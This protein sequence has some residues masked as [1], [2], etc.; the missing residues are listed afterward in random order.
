MAITFIAWATSD[1]APATTAGVDTTGANLLIAWV[2]TYGAVTPTLT[3]SKSNTWTPL[4]QINNATDGNARCRMYYATN[5]P[6]V[7]SGHTVTVSDAGVLQSISFLALA[8]A[9]ATAPYDQE[10]T[11][12]PGGT[13]TTI[14]PGSITPSEDGCVLVTGLQYGVG[15]GGVS[16]DGGFSE[17][18]Q[19]KNF[20]LAE[21]IAYLIQTTA[22]AANPT[23]TIPSG[24]IAQ[25]AMASF[26]SAGGGGGGGQPTAKRMGGV[27]FSSF[28]VG[29]QGVQVWKHQPSREELETF[30]QLTRRA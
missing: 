17:T 3:D 22:A 7:G 8:G 11:N 5:S 29:R 14:Q 20:G 9:H 25:T 2:N 24:N 16:I 12:N 6:T 15:V 1:A 21:G 18:H 30:S 19:D 4:T 23:W 10:T 26:K 27:G 13:P 28:S